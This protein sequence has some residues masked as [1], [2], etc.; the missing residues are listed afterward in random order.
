MT[1]NPS[2]ATVSGDGI[3]EYLF[4]LLW[5][6]DELNF[7]PSINIPDTI[8]FKYGQPVCWYFTATN[9]RIKKK[10]KHK[11][12]NARIEEEFNKHILGYDVVATFIHINVDNEGVKKSTIEFLDRK[13]LNDFLYKRHKETQGILQ[14]FIEPKSTKNEII[15]A[16]WSPKVCLLERAA[17]IHHLHDHRYGLN[18][19]CI[20]YEGPDYYVNSAPLRGPVLAG[21]IQTVCEA[22]VSHV[23]EV[24]FAQQQISRIVLNF[25]VDSRDKVWLLY[26]SSVRCL[27]DV[28]NPNTFDPQ[29][30]Q[31]L[32]NIDNV[33]TLSDT[34]T[35]NPHKSYEKLPQRNVGHMNCISCGKDTLENLRHPVSY[36]G[37]VKHYDHILHLMSSVYGNNGETVLTWP[38]DNEIIEAAGGVGFGC[39]S[40]ITQ[41]DYRTLKLDLRK[42]LA[43]DELRI[44]PIIRYLHPKLSAKSYAACKRDPLFLY[45]T[46]N[47]CEPCYLVYAEFT[48]MLL[49]VGQ[50]LT[51][52]LAPDPSFAS[53]LAAGTYK[54]SLENTNGN[55]NGKRPSSA[56][57]RAMSSVNK[58]QSAGSLREG[59]GS[60]QPSGNH[61]KAKHNAIGLRSSDAEMHRPPDVPEGIRSPQGTAA[62]VYKHNNEGLENDISTQGGT[63]GNAS[64][65]SS[66]SFSLGNS[67][68]DEVK[69]MIAERE[70]HFFQEISRNPQLRDQHPLMHIISAQQKLEMVDKQSGVL[71]S[72]SSNK[73]QGHFGSTRYGK[74]GKDEYDKYDC[75][76]KE[77]PYVMGGRIIKP[78]EVKMQKKLEAQRLRQLR[79]QKKQQLMNEASHGMLSPLTSQPSVGSF[80]NA[81]AIT[82]AGSDPSSVLLNTSSLDSGDVL[83][84]NKPAAK[85]R[86]FLNDALSKVEA[87]VSKKP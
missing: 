67:E 8:I 40:L 81:S 46:A 60:F 26:S 31:S 1:S 32:I 24:T 23:S 70:R 52:L 14:R 34:V 12:M 38:P 30:I 11:L 25:K 10:S 6:K 13:A 42:P 64:Y 63:F 47:V 45:K 51:K 7:G 36:K 62:L 79:K 33:V 68:H 5:T 37:I 87:E 50:D 54:N 22:I 65:A 16:I 4:N 71:S 66:A 53:T 3:S 28:V 75:Y 20:T 69:A 19:R 83:A 84:I 72:K 17:N 85:H 48:T 18:E 80:A 59:R 21:Q 44:P 49:R 55:S 43:T 9:G 73:T 56:Q 58:S 27:A 76:E 41:D 82:G 86:N 77:L 15:R 29:P 78:S 74:Q 57:W 35:L 61:T 2:N 39:L